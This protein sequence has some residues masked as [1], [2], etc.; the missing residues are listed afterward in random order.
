MDNK[1]EIM[2]LF[3]GWNDKNERI[4]ITIGENSAS[5]KWMHEKAARNYNNINKILNIIMIILSTSLSAETLFGTELLS[6]VIIKKIMIYVLTIMTVVQN[7]LKYEKLAAAHIAS[8]TNYAT[9]YHSIQQEM[10]M[11]RRNRQKATEYVSNIIKQYDS[12]IINSP[13]INSKILETFKRVFKAELPEIAD[14]QKIDIIT[15]TIPE[16][17]QI[18]KEKSIPVCNLENIRNLY[19]IQGDITDNDIQNCSGIEL[20]EIKQKYKIV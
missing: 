9:L 7:F 10:C 19:Q 5:Y 16:Q 8:A 14:K 2:E 4:I 18:Q 12:L 11:Y 17:I 13:D 1:I 15:E 3:N 6:V 20:Q